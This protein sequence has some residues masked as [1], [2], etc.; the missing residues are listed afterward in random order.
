MNVAGMCLQGSMTPSLLCC[1]S[2]HVDDCGVCDGDGSACPKVGRVSMDMPSGR[3]LT[4]VILRDVHISPA[5]EA[6]VA[7][8]KP[9]QGMHSIQTQNLVAVGSEFTD[10]VSQFETCMCTLPVSVYASPTS[11]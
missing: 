11:C 1:Q 8:E 2:G 7:R 5:L 6:G 4:Q 3:R 9:K 10:A